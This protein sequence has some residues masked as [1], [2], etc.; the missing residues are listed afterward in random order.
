[1]PSFLI[2]DIFD[3]SKHNLLEYI[4]FY[5][6]KSGKFSKNNIERG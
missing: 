4:I 3:S 6:E 1:M 2:Q 5:L